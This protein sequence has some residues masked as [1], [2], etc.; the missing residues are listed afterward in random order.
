MDL[1]GTAGNDHA[2]TVHVALQ[3][4]SLLSNVNCISNNQYAYVLVAPKAK[5][6]GRK[7][8]ERDSDLSPAE[9]IP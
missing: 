1:C 6:L 2:V 8:K 4:D 3:S 7:R 9:M 5:N